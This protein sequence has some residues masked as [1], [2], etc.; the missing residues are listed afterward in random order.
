VFAIGCNT[1]ND[2]DPGPGPG[3]DSTGGTV[4]PTQPYVVGLTV[5]GTP[6]N[7][8]FQGLAPDLTG[9]T[10]RVVWNN[11]NVE[12]IA[13]KDLADKGFYA[14][15]YCDIA[16]GPD[17]ADWDVPEAV[18]GFKIAHRGSTVLSN[19]FSL[20]GV[21]PL[22]ELTFTG[23]DVTWYSDQRPDFG[24]FGLRGQYEWI[25]DKD[26]NVVW[27]KTEDMT[28][29]GS[30]PDE[31][32]PN[33][34]NWEKLKTDTKDIVISQGYPAM[35]ITRVP[36]SGIVKVGI[37]RVPDAD[38][39]AS[40]GDANWVYDNGLNLF[41]V[42]PGTGAEYK[43]VANTNVAEYYRVVS[44]SYNNQSEGEFFAYDDEINIATGSDPNGKKLAKL[45]S[46]KL[47]FDVEYDDGQPAHTITWDNYYSN[48]L[49]AYGVSTLS[50]TDLFFNADLTDQ[51]DGTTILKI[52]EDEDNTWAF[53]MYYVPRQYGVSTYQN[54]VKVPVP[55]YTLSEPG[56]IEQ[57][58]RTAGRLLV[59][60]DATP[61]PMATL[62]D[63]SGANL[64]DAINDNWKLNATYERGA[65]KKTRAVTF[66]AAMFNGA[67]GFSG[68]VNL[69]DTWM[70]NQ[71]ANAATLGYSSGD[72]ITTQ[73]DFYLPVHYR[74]ETFT[75]EETVAIT[76]YWDF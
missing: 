56:P 27:D 9:I 58:V 59:K 51:D 7:V 35:D 16:G 22:K 2:P 24:K 17:G 34:K 65:D 19:D 66:T 68:A 32:D 61:Q 4:A 23:K 42:T 43:F 62:N 47:K 55:V 48:M 15:K 70:A 53:R 13:G 36:I 67:G 75:D 41:A 64:L 29:P 57:K 18:N 45:N 76:L 31:R 1:S 73:E 71:I 38:A 10:A 74:G 30:L 52:N 5:Q 20:P 39:T 21:I 26:G 8:S 63:A 3:T 12:F 33:P 37:G 40:P 46:A 49:Y 60:Y 6:S 25:V 72:R 11:Q 44:V 50:L 69:N 54:V 28:V 14:T